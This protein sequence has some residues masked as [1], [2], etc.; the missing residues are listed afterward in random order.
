[1][2][3]VYNKLVRDKIPEII[4]G[5]GRTPDIETFGDHDY[6]LALNRKLREE[7]DEYL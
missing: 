3:T 2:K 4:T 6:F 1:L 7:V 5:Q